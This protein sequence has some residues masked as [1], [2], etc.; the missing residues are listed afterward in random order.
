M[1]DG[2][3][4]EKLK[5]GYIC[6]TVRPI[7]TKFGL[8]THIGPPNRTGSKNLNF[9]KFKMADGRHFEKS[10]NGHMSSTVHVFLLHMRKTDIFPL[11]I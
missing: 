11:P 9:S 10:E 3:H 6:A 8:V 5:N 2:R 1:A 4:L 7:G